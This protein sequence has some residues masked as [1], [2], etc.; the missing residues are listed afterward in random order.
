[1]AKN[2]GVEVKRFELAELASKAVKRAL[3]PSN[4]KASFKRTGIWP[5]NYDSLM[6]DTSCSQVFHVDGQEEGNAQIGV[7]VQE[8]DD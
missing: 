7:K 4:I 6:H 1:M 2:P 8:V 3:T 5:L